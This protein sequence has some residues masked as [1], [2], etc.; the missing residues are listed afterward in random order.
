MTLL[1]FLQSQLPAGQVFHEQDGRVRID[2]RELNDA[3]D[4][5]HCSVVREVLD[6]LSG[7]RCCRWCCCCD[8]SPRD[9]YELKEDEQALLS[10]TELRLDPGTESYDTDVRRP[11]YQMRGRSVTQEQ[12]REII[13]RTD[14]MLLESLSLPSEAEGDCCSLERRGYIGTLNFNQWWFPRNHSPTH[15][16]WSHPSGLIGC[17]AITQRWPNFTELLTELLSWKRAFPYLDLMIAIS[18]WNEHPPYWHDAH[19][20]YFHKWVLRFDDLSAEEKR[21]RDEAEE[22]ITY[23]EFPD[24][25]DNLEIGVCTHDHVIEFLNPENAARKYREYAERYEA[26]DPRIY[27]PEYYEDHGLLICD[28]AY[29]LRCLTDYGLSAQQAREALANEPGYQWLDSAF[30]DRK[31]ANSDLP[32]KA[33]P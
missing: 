4:A 18:D 1:E 22:R 15:Y 17:N 25:C 10:G 14:G 21:Q 20:E 13:R 11:Y 2:L 30:P 28:N 3:E 7:G 16:G 8:D 26:A 6:E 9:Y 5:S 19:D 29:L 27:V 12:A 23:M 24:F 33:L 32:E 31:R